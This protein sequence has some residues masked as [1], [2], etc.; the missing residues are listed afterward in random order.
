MNTSIYTCICR[1]GLNCLIITIVIQA[2]LNS[3]IPQ[4]QNFYFEL[5]EIEI[6]GRL[7]LNNVKPKIIILVF[8]IK[9]NVL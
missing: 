4:D 8:S 9:T 2:N 6:K 1:K 3:R 7:S 5:T